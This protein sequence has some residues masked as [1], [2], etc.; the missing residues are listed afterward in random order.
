MGWVMAGLLARCA[1]GLLSSPS[2]EGQ[3]EREEARPGARPVR[4]SRT[5]RS[6]CTEAPQ[7]GK[8]NGIP[9]QSGPA[10]AVVINRSAIKDCG[11]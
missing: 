11:C 5:V 8:P 4:E 7:A 9:E 10:A 2:R 3:G 1:G 6:N